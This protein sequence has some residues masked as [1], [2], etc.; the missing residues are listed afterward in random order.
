M[1]GNQ[2]FEY[3]KKNEGGQKNEKKLGAS[4]FL[5]LFF[6]NFFVMNHEVNA[7]SNSM[8]RMNIHVQLLENGTG[9]I[10]EQRD[11]DMQEGTEL[12]IVLENLQKAEL[13]DFEVTGFQL[14]EDWNSNDSREDKAGHYGVID[15]RKGH[16]LVWG[17]GE[18]GVNEYELTYT[19]SNLVR[20]LRD[21]QSLLWDFNSFG[22]IPPAEFTME[23]EG[24]EPFTMENTKIWGYGL[25]G[26]IQLENGKI[27]WRSTGVLNRSSYATVLAQFSEEIFSPEESERTTLEKQREKAMDGSAYNQSSSGNTA[28]IVLRVILSIIG[29]V[30]VLYIA[31]VRLIRVKTKGIPQFKSQ[32][33][34]NKENKGL[35]Y[36]QVPYEDDIA[37]IA[38]L[39]HRSY[40][41]S[42]DKYFFAYLLKWA[43]EDRI[44]IETEEV[45]K[46]LSSKSE[47]TIRILN[48]EAEMEA[49]ESFLDGYIEHV[50]ASDGELS[51]ESAVWRT[52]LEAA[53]E[54]GI[55]TDK[56]MKKWAEKHGE[57]IQELERKLPEYSM[58]ALERKGYVINNETKVLGIKI[59]IVSPTEKGQELA[60][61]LKQFEN[62]LKQMNLK[63][64]ATY[65]Q[66]MPWEDLVIWAALYGRAE[67]IVK[68][69][70]SFYPEVWQEWS[71]EYPYFYGGF[72]GYHG[73]NNSF[74]QG[75]GSS[76]YGSSGAGGSTS[77][78][79]G[80]GA[81]GGGGGGAR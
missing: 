49:V 40:V 73:F 70:E 38:Y 2:A 32:R 59:P 61:R 11:M 51:F 62:Y 9:I 72:H 43:R 16:E 42:F 71:Q 1:E 78:G 47:A 19:L 57:E 13:L 28:N 41:G 52:V 6:L 69:L 8:P 34:L 21:G 25:P 7:A 46:F 33:K 54:Q 81:G 10:T 50:L 53:D 74:S 5:F 26:D 17:I 29:V 60:V 64:A 77:G 30:T 75:F 24:P 66:N 31:F 23:I 55:V 22:D 44:H 12:Y 37:D 80:G 67:L 79:G 3:N 65:K 15:K 76:G 4:G 20:Q 18:Y 39:L 63:E 48:Y 56:A 58:K 36:D 68:Q 27:I 45:K 35:I 14:Q